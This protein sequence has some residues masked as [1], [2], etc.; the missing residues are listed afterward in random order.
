V[1]FFFDPLV[2]F[3]D[4]LNPSSIL[5]LLLLSVLVSSLKEHSSSP[6]AN[7]FGGKVGFEVEIGEFQADMLVEIHN[8]GPVTILLDTTPYN[9]RSIRTR[10]STS[11]SV[12]I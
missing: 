9:P 2:I 3:A 1:I 11:F 7:S 5:Y 6:V 12:L 10:S 4:F 8:S